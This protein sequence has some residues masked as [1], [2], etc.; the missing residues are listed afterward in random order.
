MDLQKTMEFIV[1]HQAALTARLEQLEAVSARHSRDLEVHTEWKTGMSRALQDLAEQMKNGFVQMAARHNE[2]AA[3]H[4]ELAAA[5]K[6]LTEAQK[7][8][9]ESLNILI[10]TV[11]EILPRLPKQ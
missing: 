5:Q 8:T 11:Q 2:L 7:D 10:R 9:R 1:E 3:A 4:K 6:N